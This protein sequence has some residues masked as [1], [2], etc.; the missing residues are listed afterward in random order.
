MARQVANSPRDFARDSRGSEFFR[1][2]WFLT[3]VGSQFV[4]LT[5]FC[6]GVHFNSM[7]LWCRRPHE[8]RSFYQ[9]RVTLSWLCYVVWDLWIL[10]NLICCKFGSFV[11]LTHSARIFCQSISDHITID[12][13]ITHPVIYS[14]PSNITQTLMIKTSTKLAS[15]TGDFLVSQPYNDSW[16]NSAKCA[17]SFNFDEILQTG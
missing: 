16:C 8:T 3:V 2:V 12:L 14:N 7:F 13:Q 9:E 15:S 4:F 10:T 11:H 5:E 17:R 6:N 1:K